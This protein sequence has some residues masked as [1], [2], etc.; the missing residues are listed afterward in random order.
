[1]RCA[2]GDTRAAIRLSGRFRR[3]G[4]YPAGYPFEIL[5]CETCGLAR[6]RPT[7][8]S[9]QYAAGEAHSSHRSVV[10]DSYSASLAADAA[11]IAP[12]G[13]LLD[14]GCSTGEVVAHALAVGMDAEGIDADPGPV[15]AGVALGRPLKVASL[16]ELSGPY[17]VILMNHTLEHVHAPVPFLAAARAL[18]SPGGALLVNVPNH[19]SPVALV[20]RDQ[21]IG[22]LPTEHVFHYSR[23]TLARVAA[24][25]GLRIAESSTAGVIEPPSAGVKG[26]VKKAVTVAARRAGRGD[27]LEC[28]LRQAG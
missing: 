7:P 19:E 22:W 6:T 23:T 8:S 16:A 2:C 20:M 5:V 13:R 12:G 27:E 17:D 14:V 11:R 1:M 9:T 3:A 24:P 28:V 18:L 10:G 4:G 26:L 25:A 15:A 21:W